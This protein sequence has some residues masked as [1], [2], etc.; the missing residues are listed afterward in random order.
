M[1][2]AAAAIGLGGILVSSLLLAAG[3]AGAPSQY[4]PA[5]S[6]GWPGWLA[7]PLSGLHLG[8]PGSRFQALLIVMCAGYALA[9]SGAAGLSARALAACVVL[10]HVIF[11]LAPP[12]IS[13]DVFGYISF[14][15]MGALHGL[16]PYTHFPSEAPTDPTFHFLGWP[17]QHSP[18]GPLFTLLGYA[19]APLGVAA[20]VWIYKALAALTSLAAVALIARGAERSGHSPRW[21]A[22]FVGLNP[23]LLAFAVGGAHNDTLL[24]LCFALA[25][26]LTAAP[27]PD[28]GTSATR[29]RT[30]AYAARPGAA[31][32]ALV[33]GVG[34]KV[35]AALLLPFLA[36]GRHRPRDRS[37]VVTAAAA[38]LVA[39]ALVGLVGFGAHAFGF[40]DAVGEQQ[41]LVAIHSVPAET[42]RLVGLSGTPAWWRHLFLAVFALVVVLALAATARGADWRTTAGWA[43]L[44]LLLCTAWLLPWY[45]IWLLPLAAVG[46]DRRLR[47]A[48]LVVCAYAVLIH[49]SLADPLLDPR[50]HHVPHHLAF[51]LPGFVHRIELTGF[52]VLGHVHRDLRW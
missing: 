18:Y 40:L 14:G 19:L 22:A 1:L 29:G 51:P 7:G 15:R 26:W 21:A 44:A 24:L 47:A 39:L 48:A 2:R 28:P 41:Q 45:A 32:A 42:A 5:R 43:T 10:A 25:L 12:L 13:Q 38:G 30:G 31:A 49:L 20:D 35:S 8:L 6:G 9:L 27:A 11:A 46:G 23:V 34:V 17:F 4:V 37:R 50:P 52:E 16:D 33:A 3:A 36:L